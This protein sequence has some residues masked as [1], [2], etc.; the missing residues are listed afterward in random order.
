MTDEK[1]QQPVPEPEIVM[2]KQVFP[3]GHAFPPELLEQWVAIPPE[4]PLT[5]GPL[6]RGTL[7]QFLFAITDIAGAIAELRFALIAYSNGKIDRA[8][9]HL[10]NSTLLLAD[11]ETRNRLLFDSII[12]SAIEVRKN[13]G[14]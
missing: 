8:D 4:E 1:A 10:I 9:K 7:D 12:R 13:A 2:H 3:E 5:I 11:G 6:S 14:K